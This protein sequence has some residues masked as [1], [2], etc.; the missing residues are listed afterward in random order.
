MT[1]KKP[2]PIMK[3]LP[4][5]SRYLYPV[6]FILFSIYIL[7]VEVGTAFLRETADMTPFYT[8]GVF[9]RDILGRV[10]GLVFYLSS[11]MQDLLYYPWL[12]TVMFI[13]LLVAL[14]YA[15]KWSFRIHDGWFGWC[16]LPSLLL[17]L[18]D[19]QL[20]YFIYLLKL[21]AVAFTPAVG[22]LMAVSVVGLMARMGK[23][24]PVGC[25]L[26]STVGYWLMGFYAVLA[27]TLFVVMTICNNRLTLSW[28]VS[29]L[30][31][32]LL[33]V[34]VPQV[35]YG[36][37]HIMALRSAIY[38]IGLPDFRLPSEWRW[39][40]PCLL[41]FA[42]L[43]ILAIVPRGKD[44]RRAW[45][46]SS[47]LFVLGCVGT[48]LMT[49]R[50]A[51]LR[52]IV[53]MKQAIENQDYQRVLDIA[54]ANTQEP[55]RLQVMFTRLALMRMG[56]LADAAFQYPDGAAPYDCPRDEQFLQL[57]GGRMLYY[58]F[59]MPNYAYR[60]GMEGMVEYGMRPEYVRWMY[61]C[62]LVNGAT[63]LAN[64]YAD[65]LRHTWF[66][67]PLPPSDAEIAAVR[68]LMEYEN[69]LDYDQ[70][71]VEGFLLKTFTQLLD[72]GRNVQ[73]L[74]LVCSMIR[75]DSQAFWSHFSRWWES[76]DAEGQGEALPLHLQEAALLF[77]QMFQVDID[78]LPID[79]YTVQ[80]YQ[81]FFAQV[82]QN[83]NDEYS[84]TALKPQFGNTYWYY[85]FYM[86]NIVTY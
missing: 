73:E 53:E 9:A 2:V 48:W 41:A 37:G 81:D 34:I 17:L 39:M 36:M 63:V 56:H 86:D 46:V 85:F 38:T 23:M 30:L 59:G 80:R 66:F 77:S 43:I 24:S 18:H 22:V 26:L 76:L 32:S 70:G 51:N 15:V 21:P 71:V 72:G 61:R 16:W 25:V 55:T 11:L 62:A 42:I 27:M 74:S 29:L 14:A 3:R 54:T 35:L 44:A 1:D 45:L 83:A 50:D 57:I 10:G 4:I 79:P 40:I 47:V 75:K 67:H 20:G 58:H 84:R 65:L 12:G 69:R 60:W 19:S 64:K 49:N 78:G 33:V 7:C 82:R 68:E 5:V 31:L 13:V 28:K 8:D 6:F 52:A